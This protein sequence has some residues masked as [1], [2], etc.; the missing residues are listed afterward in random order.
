MSAEYKAEEDEDVA[1]GCGDDELAES[2]ESGVAGKPEALEGRRSG[3][4][5]LADRVPSGPTVATLNIPFTP[6]A[7][8][9]K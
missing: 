5:V 4:G 3:S 6:T 2:V 9:F 8:V 1:P 7:L